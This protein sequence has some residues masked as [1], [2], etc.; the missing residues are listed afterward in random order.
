[1]TSAP[2]NILVDT[3]VWLD[4]FIPYRAARE[5]SC[6]FIEYALS[7]KHNLLFTLQTACD[8]YAKVGIEAKT[9]VRA[10]SSLTEAWSRA[11]RSSAWDCVHQM[12][13]MGTVVGA[14][15]S[16]LWVACRLREVHNDLEDDLILAACERAKVDYLVTKDKKLITDAP[17]AALTP[18]KMTLVLKSLRQP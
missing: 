18:A 4:V 14:D 17:V 3:N 1:M 2:L 8:V 11:I 16:D 10:S 6:E 5:Q 15:G 13:E 9:W 7:M 12:Q